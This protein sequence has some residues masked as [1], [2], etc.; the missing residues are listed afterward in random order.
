MADPQVV[1]AVKRRIAAGGK[2]VT[3][4]LQ[5][6]IGQAL[7]AQVAAQDIV[8]ATLAVRGAGEAVDALR[9]K[10][11]AQTASAAQ[12]GRAAAWET[13]DRAAFGGAPITT[14][15]LAPTG[16]AAPS[17]AVG[18]TG[19]P[20][21]PAPPAPNPVE[22]HGSILD[23]ITQM[24]PNPTDPTYKADGGAQAYTQD[25]QTW[26]KA[27]GE[28]VQTQEALDN[29][30]LGIVKLPNGQLFFKGDLSKL[31]PQEQ[32]QIIP[33]FEQ[34]SIDAQNAYTDSLNKYGLSQFNTANA[35]ATT[36]NEAASKT[37]QG[38]LDVLDRNLALGKVDQ[39]T[40]LKE[41]DR[42]L[43]GMT[44]SR[45]RAKFVDDALTAADPLA[46]SGGKTSFSGADLGAGVA[47]L[48]RA[49][50]IPD[51]MPLLSFTGT[52]TVDPQGQ[53]NW[54]DQQLGVT[55]QLP[56]V[57]HYVQL[58]SDFAVRPSDIPAAPQYAGAPAVPTLRAPIA[59]A[60]PYIPRLQFGNYPGSAAM[61]PG[62]Y[63]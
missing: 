49:A 28:A 52:R 5:S 36:N 51:G 14:P 18:A 3:F 40:A 25:I 58:P 55:G 19:A 12:T 1:D 22:V 57:P 50:G 47:G 13:A 7:D 35:A 62:D 38:K 44:E 30:H 34:Q 17:G 39:D 24:R 60:L 32:Q 33:L 21:K 53:L 42:Q 56:K 29:Q 9:A 10:V 46:T 23:A 27:L 15:T 31:T 61:P 11:R 41:I 6:A 20:V 37:F 63:E 43:T 59:P 2:T 26:A 45:T 16:A 8:D 4:A 48:S 54:Q